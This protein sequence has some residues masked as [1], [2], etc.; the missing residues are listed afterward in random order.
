VESDF[1]VSIMPSRSPY[2]NPALPRAQSP[3]RNLHI[4]NRGDIDI[5]LEPQSDTP[6]HPGGGSRAGAPSS[7]FSGGGATVRI[8][9]TPVRAPR[10]SPSPSPA[11]INRSINE[12][13]RQPSPGPLSQS[14]FRDAPRDRSSPVGA[15]QFNRRYHDSVNA[16]GS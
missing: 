16:T 7:S 2:S 5:T 11:M 8:N 13:I 15:E 3:V 10:P 4:S 9:G 14:I 12:S 1:S 6:W